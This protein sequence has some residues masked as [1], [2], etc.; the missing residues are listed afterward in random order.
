LHWCSYCGCWNSSCDCFAW[1]MCH[2]IFRCFA[3]CT[4]QETV[5]WQKHYVLCMG[6]L[7][8]LTTCIT[9]HWDHFTEASHHLTVL[10][11]AMSLCP[12]GL[13]QSI[14]INVRFI[15]FLKKV[16][17]VFFLSSKTHIT[18]KNCI[19]YCT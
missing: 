9:L 17:E 8:H 19:V 16:L 10:Q 12:C 4:W 7:F 1:N 14:A 11:F 15:L 2:K 3:L 5:N 6:T 18:P 13:V